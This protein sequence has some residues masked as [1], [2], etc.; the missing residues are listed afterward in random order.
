M[1]RKKKIVSVKQSRQREV[2]WALYCTE[3]YIGNLAHLQA[4]NAYTMTKADL[5]LISQ[6]KKSAEVT[7]QLLREALVE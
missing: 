4:V 5:R 6:A 2:S 1:R 3:G 7:A